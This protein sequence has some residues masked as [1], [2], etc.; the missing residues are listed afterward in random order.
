MSTALPYLL[1]GGLALIAGLCTLAVINDLR[2]GTSRFAS[3][4]YDVRRKELP[5]N[6]WLGVASKAVGALT[7]LLLIIAI[8][9]WP[10]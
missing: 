10:L 6:F 7:A 4:L 2:T 9:S 3:S 1:I 8:V 5:L